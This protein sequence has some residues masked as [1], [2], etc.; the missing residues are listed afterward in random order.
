[1]WATLSILTSDDRYIEHDRYTIL[2]NGDNGYNFNTRVAW[3]SDSVLDHFV[4]VQSAPIGV[5]ADQGL[6]TFVNLLTLPYIQD[7]TEK[8]EKGPIYFVSVSTPNRQTD[9][10]K[11]QNPL[12]YPDPIKDHLI[13]AG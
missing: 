8:D 9:W 1:M 3:A 2:G 4:Q 13:K 12:R 11:C 10:M 6:L 7:N 5:P